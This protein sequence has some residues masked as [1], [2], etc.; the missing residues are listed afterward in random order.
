MPK[1]K[2]L[3]DNDVLEMFSAIGEMGQFSKFIRDLCQQD[4]ELSFNASNDRD[5]NVLRGAHD[6]NLYFISLIKKA[7]DRKA[8]QASRR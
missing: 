1:G 8:K 6:R 4:K 2:S 5:R 3:T 7:H